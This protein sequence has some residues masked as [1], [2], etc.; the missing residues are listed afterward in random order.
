MVLTF[1]RL[2][3]L[4]SVFDFFLTNITEVAKSPLEAADWERAIFK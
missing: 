1:S 2:E 4:K 3:K